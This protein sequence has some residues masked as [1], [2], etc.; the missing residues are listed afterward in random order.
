MSNN[1][2]YVLGEENK[3]K[4][5]YVTS[6]SEL[7]ANC[8]IVANSTSSDGLYVSSGS[9]IEATTVETVGGTHKSAVPLHAQ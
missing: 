1:C 5:L 7:I 4:M 3:E 2:I 8:G 9:K 6:D